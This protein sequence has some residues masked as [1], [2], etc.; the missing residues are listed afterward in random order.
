MIEAL[1][2]GKLYGQATQKTARSGNPFTT[3]KVRVPTTGD[4]TI[5]C[6]VIAFSDS[7]QA[8]LLALGDGDAVALAGTIK[9][10]AW[11]DREGQA[12]PSLDM[13]AAQVLTVYH[14]KRKR[15]AVAPDDE[16]P[17]QAATGTRSKF[18]NPDF[19]QP[20]LDGPTPDGWDNLDGV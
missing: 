5:F 9:P 3:A 1:L 8:A 6:N 13:T 11:V 17:R 20:D 18:N 7:A 2:T 14:L 15:A 12:R 19:R 16:P 4:E 10:G